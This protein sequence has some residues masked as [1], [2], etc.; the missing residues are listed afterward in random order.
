MKKIISLLLV[1]I[2]CV[3]LVA[4]GGSDQNPLI[5]SYVENNRDEMIAGFE[6]GFVTTSNM[7]CKTEIEVVGNGIVISI[8]INE[9]NDLSSE[10]KAA[11]QA[12]YDMMDQQFGVLLLEMKQE[13]PGL[14][15]FTFNFCEADGDLMATVTKG[16]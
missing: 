4:C 14:E 8:N 16:K 2:L 15:Y 5:V 12:G 3:A 11:M 10:Q 13:I 6:E 1:A 9:L 7:T